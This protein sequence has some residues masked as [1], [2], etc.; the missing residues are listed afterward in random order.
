MNEYQ[1]MV[2]LALES[3][4]PLKLILKGFAENH[5]GIVEVVYASLDS[6][7]TRLK[8]DELTKNTEEYY[9]VYAVPFDTDLNKLSHY[10]SIEIGKE[11][12]L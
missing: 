11:D 10:P 5:K 3:S 12:L 2:N 4:E 7:K 1:E 9:M 8:F 6:D